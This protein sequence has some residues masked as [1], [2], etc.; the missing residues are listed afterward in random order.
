[1]S[2]RSPSARRAKLTATCEQPRGATQAEGVAFMASPMLWHRPSLRVARST[3]TTTTTTEAVHVCSSS[4]RVSSNNRSHRTMLALVVLLTLAGVTGQAMAANYVVYLQGRSMNAWPQQALLAHSAAYTDITLSCNGSS[5]L[6]DSTVR[7]QIRAALANCC[8]NGNQCVV[9]CYSAGALRYLLA[10]DDLKAIGTPATGVAHSASRVAMREPTTAAVPGLALRVIAA[11]LAT[12][13]PS[14]I[15]RKGSYSPR[16]I[17][18]LNR[19]HKQ[20]QR[21]SCA[22]RRSTAVTCSGTLP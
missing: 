8:S 7:P 4:T 18:P 21:R 10:I 20:D 22:S 17:Q 1:V 14:S 15:D 19:A 6:A 5:R 12:S 11:A 3:T 13:S 16:Q 9:V 2:A